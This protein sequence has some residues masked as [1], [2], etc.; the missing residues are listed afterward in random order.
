MI[1][2]DGIR[3]AVASI[4][5][6]RRAIDESGNEPPGLALPAPPYFDV[7]IFAVNSG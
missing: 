4:A 5:A 7:A 1:A 6:Q 2:R 3:R